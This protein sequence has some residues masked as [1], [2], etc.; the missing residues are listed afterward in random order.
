MREIISIFCDI[1]FETRQYTSSEAK[2][3]QYINKYLKITFKV[4][5]FNYLTMK[6]YLIKIKKNIIQ[7]NSTL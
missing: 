2:N 1:I 3:S 4:M 5:L 6:K 7:M